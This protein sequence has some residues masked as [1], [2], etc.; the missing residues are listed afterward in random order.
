MVQQPT[1]CS[2][3]GVHRTEEAPGLG[4]QPA[5]CGGPH[6][7]KVSTSVHTAEMGQIA[8]EVQLVGHNTQARVLQEAETLIK[9]KALKTS[10]FFFKNPKLSVSDAFDKMTKLQG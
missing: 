4:E 2:V 3:W 10:Q 9:N 5:H 7:G 6:L 8:D 1:R